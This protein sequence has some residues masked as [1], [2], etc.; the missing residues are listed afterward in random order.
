[1]LSRVRPQIRLREQD[2]P[3]F[4][5]RRAGVLLQPISDRTDRHLGGEVDGVSV[6]AG[7]DGGERDTGERLEGGE[8]EGGAMG[9]GG[10]VRLAGRAATPDR[11]DRVDDATRGEPP[12]P[13]RDSSARGQ[14]VRVAGP[15]DLAALL[16][17]GGTALPVDR[18][19]DAAAA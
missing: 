6:G 16:E 12:C 7:A 10:R 2:E 1:Q 8:V 4:P 17:D 11:T 5:N 15:A 9:G 13:G 18:A 14:S 19:I 3:D